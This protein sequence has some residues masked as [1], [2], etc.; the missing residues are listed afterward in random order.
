MNLRTTNA[1]FACLAAAGLVAIP[2]ARGLAQSV[3]APTPQADRGNA[4]Q[5]TRGERDGE[6]DRMVWIEGGEFLMGGVGALARPDELARHRVRVSGFWIDATEVTNAQFAKFVEATGYK[7]VAERPIDW[8]E[9]RK[10]VPAGTPKPPD[11]VLQPGSLAFTPPKDPVRLDDATAWW[12]WT[13]GANWRHPEGPASTIAGRED[14]PVVHI[15]FE[16]AEAYARWA[17]KRLPT[18]AEWEFAARGGLEGKANIWGDEP[19]D[20]TRCN[21]WTGHF[22]DVNTKADGFDRTAPVKRYAP[23]GYGLY[24]MAGNVWEWCSDRYREDTLRA[25]AAALGPNGVATDPKGPAKSQDPRHPD[26]PE[27]RVMRGGSY[28]CSDSYCASY[29]P[30]ARMS[31]P[32][33]TGL[34]HL[35]F[36]CVRDGPR[37][38]SREEHAKEEAS[39]PATAPTSPGAPKTP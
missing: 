22:P 23:N 26:A 39:T 28:L 14:H 24:D 8:E 36:R 27:T 21:I 32:P 2:S 34:A 15:A 4:A 16:D 10:Q 11:E 7:T 5:A 25:R 31:T 33:D 6:R 35:G 9:L 18:E 3:D 30:S 29:R 1:R 19:V 12:S 17:G 37:E 13:L 38:A 20:A